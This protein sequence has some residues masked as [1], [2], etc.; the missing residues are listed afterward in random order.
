M[1]KYKN[2]LLMVIGVLLLCGCAFDGERGIKPDDDLSAYVCESIGDTFR[3]IGKKQKPNDVTDY[4]YYAPY[5]SLT[6]ENISLFM[7]TVAEM[8]VNDSERIEFNICPQIPGGYG[9][10]CS[11]QNYIE[12]TDDDEKI[13]I[14]YSEM[15]VYTIGYQELS[16]PILTD[17][18]TFTG[19][20]GVKY[21]IISSD[22]QEKA[23]EAGIDWYEIWP[24]LEGVEVF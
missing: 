5:S 24:D 14:G 11:L 15:C 19:V 3:Y 18:T 2:I 13:Y 12:L 20:K 1:R 10:T 22:M 16:E 17:P 9:G 7:N 4:M 8:S 23:D 6:A 21:L